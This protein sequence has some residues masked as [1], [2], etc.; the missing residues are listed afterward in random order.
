MDGHVSST[1]FLGNMP[2]Q[3]AEVHERIFMAGVAG[4]IAAKDTALH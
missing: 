3:Q 4:K 1:T 2:V